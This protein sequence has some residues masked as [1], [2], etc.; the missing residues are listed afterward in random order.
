MIS[1]VQLAAG[2][3]Q[4]LGWPYRSPGTNDQN[5]IDCS[6]AFVRAYRMHGQNIAHGSNTIYRKHCSVVGLI[7]GDASRLQMGMAVF[8]HRADGGEPDKF[9]GDGNGNMYH[10]GLVT[11]TSPLRI[12]HATT[13]NAKADTVLGQW[14]HYGWLADVDY[15]AGTADMPDGGTTLT[16]EAE[17]TYS[18]ENATVMLSPA[19]EA[20]VATPA[21]RYV[22]V[23]TPDG[24]GVRIRE[25]PDKTAV[26]K[27][28]PAPDGT[29][30]QVLGSKGDWYKVH[31]Q[32]KA[33][34]VMKVFTVPH[35]MKG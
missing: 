26:T 18:W 32:G 33:R 23:L 4:I 17:E 25:A 2:F 21:Q 20:P 34:W 9:K 14:S 12:V 6:G 29:I 8:K 5:G 27:F 24:H 15:S 10:I 19:Q 1:A 3:E 13:P 22:R 28:P 31:Y 7:G 16:V 11:S 35:E 30:L